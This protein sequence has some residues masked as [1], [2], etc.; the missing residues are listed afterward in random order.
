MHILEAIAASLLDLADAK[1]VL[2][3]ELT[4]EV[5]QVAGKLYSDYE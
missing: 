1:R 5:R 2:L 3:S 4:L